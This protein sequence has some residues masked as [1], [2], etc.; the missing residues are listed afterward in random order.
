[1]MTQAFGQFH[2]R[3]S[4]SRG[5]S[6]MEV[7][8]ALGIFAVGFTT[9]AAMFPT[10]IILQQRAATDVLKDHSRASIEAMVATRGLSIDP[11]TGVVP[12][13]YQYTARLGEPSALMPLRYSDT[14][15]VPEDYLNAHWPV[16]GN[17]FPSSAGSVLERRVYWLP[18]IRDELDTGT[19]MPLNRQWEMVVFVLQRGGGLEYD[20]PEIYRPLRTG[21]GAPDEEKL[22]PGLV[23]QES[24]LSGLEDDDDVFTLTSAEDHLVVGS[25]VVDSLGRIYRVTQIDGNRVRLNKPILP[26]P[27]SGAYPEQI[28]HARFGQAYIQGPSA[29][30]VV[31]EDPTLAVFRLTQPTVSEELP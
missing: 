8:I 6:L 15:V 11:A 7:L 9:L 30:A 29:G 25:W 13:Y 23:V 21:S 5:F 16:A 26:H 17:S 1:M 18:L 10:A 12:E 20:A 22:L 31:Q 14:S 2:G 3:V 27:T 24:A 28:W 19:G 4:R